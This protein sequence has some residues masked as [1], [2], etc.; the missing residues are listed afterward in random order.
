MKTPG[1]FRTQALRHLARLEKTLRV[2]KHTLRAFE[3]AIVPPDEDFTGEGV[4]GFYRIN[5]VNPKFT[6]WI[7]KIIGVF[8]KGVCVRI[9]SQAQGFPS[10][11]RSWEPWLDSEYPIVSAV[12]SIPILRQC[13]NGVVRYYVGLAP[14]RT[15]GAGTYL[16]G[17]GGF[18]SNKKAGTM[19]DFQ[20][21]LP[22]LE[23]D[24]NLCNHGPWHVAAIQE[25]K[26][27][28]LGNLHPSWGMATNVFWQEPCHDAEVYGSMVFG[29]DVPSDVDLARLQGREPDVDQGKTCWIEIESPL[30][31]GLRIL[32]AFGLGMPAD[33]QTAMAINSAAAVLEALQEKHQTDDVWRML[34]NRWPGGVNEEVFK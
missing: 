18:A 11:D 13:K 33:P 12:M 28:L 26:E 25:L 15:Q 7:R 9:F 1:E 10:Y 30:T 3:G 29:Y 32:A 4:I 21:F 6:S 23:M 8:E 17:A 20:R 19:E 31:R 2:S 14:K 27:E 34:C 16:K 24:A 5:C 22:G